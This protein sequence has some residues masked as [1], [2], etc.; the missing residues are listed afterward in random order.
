M[1]TH[2]A[3]LQNINTLLQVAVERLD[4]IVESN[5]T[6]VGTMTCLSNDDVQDGYLSFKVEM[7]DTNWVPTTFC[8]IYGNATVTIAFNTPTLEDNASYADGV[9]KV[10]LTEDY[11]TSS[12]WYIR[13]ENSE[14]GKTIRRYFDLHC[15]VDT[16]YIVYA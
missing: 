8:G 5:T 15:E 3:A 7:T 2:L 13:F 1:D 10:K 14:T 9:I 4:A 6:P 12:K 16:T 11:W